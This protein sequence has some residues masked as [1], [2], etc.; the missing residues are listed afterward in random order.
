MNYTYVLYVHAGFLKQDELT[1]SNIRFL[2]RYG[3]IYGVPKDRIPASQLP[4]TRDGVTAPSNMWSVTVRGLYEPSNDI[5]VDVEWTRPDAQIRTE[6]SNTGKNR[7][8]PIDVTLP[9]PPMRP[10][11]DRSGSEPSLTITQPQSNQYFPTGIPITCAATATNWDGA[12]LTGSALRWSAVDLAPDGGYVPNSERQL[13]EGAEVV[14]TLPHRPADVDA[15]RP[16]GYSV[17]VLARGTNDRT[18]WREVK[19]Q[20]GSVIT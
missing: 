7:R 8:T 9:G 2:D 4:R 11:P 6:E 5:V 20:V 1:D 12:P 10:P 3:A 15:N 18:A 13:G 17:A 19:I 14:A 16:S